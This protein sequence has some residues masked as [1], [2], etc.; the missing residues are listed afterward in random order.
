[1]AV[2]RAGRRVA[3]W[4]LRLFRRLPV[5]GWELATVKFRS[6]TIDLVEHRWRWITVTSLVSHL[7]L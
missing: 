4:A 2:R 3:S 7:S 6:R 5:A 1:M